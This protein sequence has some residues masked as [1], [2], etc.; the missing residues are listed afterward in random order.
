MGMSYLCEEKP[1][2]MKKCCFLILLLIAVSH[3]FCQTAENESPMQWEYFVDLMATEY[4][5]EESMDRELMEQLFELHSNPLDIN[6]LAQED[7]FVLPFLNE[8]QISDITRYIEKNKPVYSL[9]E[10]MFISS[11][12]R[13]DR[14][15][16]KLFVRVSPKTMM[17]V[18][19]PD[20]TA[21]SRLKEG[22][23]ELVVRSDIPFYQRAG[24]ADLPQEVLDKSPNKVYRGD[25]LHH[26]FRY[27]FASKNH[28]FAGMQM[29]KDAGEKGIDHVAGYIML[30]D[31]G[32]VK[33]AIV[34][35]YK[36]SFGK[37]LAVNTSAKFGKMMMIN[38]VDKMD[39]GITKHSSTAEAGYFTGGGATLRLDGWTLSAFASRR[40]GDGTY[41][42]DSA[43]ISSLKT[44]GL[45]RTQLE[46]SKKGNVGITDVGG[47]V[48]WANDFLQLS[49]TAV[50]THFS[51]PL[52]PKNDT[53]SS[54]YRLYNAS[55]KDFLVGSLSY[56]CRLN[57]IT[58]GGE[59]AYSATDK[60][61]GFATL[62]SIRWRV[63]G[64]NTLTLIGR[65]YGA[66]FVSINGK[67]FGEN[68]SV[69]NEDGIF[70][71]WS[72]SAFRNLLIDTYVDAMHFPW[73][74]QGVSGSSY[75]YE[76][77]AQAVYSPREEWS[78]QARYRIKSKQKDFTYD[79]NDGKFTVL[80]YNTN[81]NLKLQLNCKL[82]PSVSLRASAIG[83]MVTFGSNPNEY[84]FAAGGNIRWKSL[85]SQCRIDVGF[86]Y[87]DTDSYNARVYNYEPTLLYSFGSTSYY[88]KGIRTTLLAN[89]PIIK[90]QLFL[91]AKLG[92][93]KY[94]NRDTIGSGLQMIDSCHRE[95]L[96]VQVRWRF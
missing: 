37:G 32:V 6:T 82:S 80:E 20:I 5:E 60:Q 90:N 55:G 30:Q 61:N 39:A 91:N 16:L 78:L 8:E 13:A 73:M 24:F 27:A 56:S 49:A 21:K 25:P 57:A 18:E 66:K 87:F 7:L 65:H 43:G 51:I 84:G 26:A 33:R 48:H 15:M 23:H 62:N 17:E 14:E 92:M 79:R 72:S 52:A 74:K 31:I 2:D 94:F 86:T 85:K 89:I 3:A 38:S 44:D 58:L 63:D 29:E 88:Y 71:G 54:Y 75:G 34:G 22:K 53:E 77:V 67:A 40:Q 93:T 4:G 83:T 64:S 47:N 35:N 95:D 46:R 50:A 70:L 10:L 11:L 12:G 76:G 9:G 41:S 69:Q 45:H 96:Q 19:R 81:Q 1:K 42:K 59:T 68:A 28:L 36:I